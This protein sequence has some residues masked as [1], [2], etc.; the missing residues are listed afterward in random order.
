[1]ELDRTIS[2][3]LTLDCLLGL[4]LSL[5]WRAVSLA[6]ILYVLSLLLVQGLAQSWLEN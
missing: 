6:I 4:F 2:R 5:L 1:M 3:Q